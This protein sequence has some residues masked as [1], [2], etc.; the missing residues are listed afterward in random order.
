MYTREKK[1]K[2]DKICWLTALGL[3]GHTLIYG[4][5]NGGRKSLWC[6]VIGQ[7]VVPSHWSSSGRRGGGRGGW[8]KIGRIWLMLEVGVCVSALKSWYSTHRWCCSESGYRLP[9]KLQIRG[10]PR[11]PIARMH[12]FIL[13][14][15]GYSCMCAITISHFKRVYK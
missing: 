4:N 8:W 13:F 2:T 9:D 10:S 12:P 6:Y 5:W 3:P 7:C 1:Q 14:A 15:C 11:L